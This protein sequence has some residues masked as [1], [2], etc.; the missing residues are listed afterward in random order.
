MS[1]ASVHWEEG[2]F[3]RPHH[4]QASQRHGAAASSLGDKWDRHHNW[5]LRGLDLNPDALSNNRFEVRSLRA[6]MRDGTLVSVP[7]DGV[8]TPLDLKA[9]LE[10]GRKA[11]VYLAVPVFHPSRNNV[12]Q[13]GQDGHVRYRVESRTLEDENTGVNPQSV[14]FRRLNLELLAEGQ[15]LTGYEVLPIARMERSA[16]AEATPQLDRSYIPPL[17]ACDGWAPLMQDVLRVIYDRLGRKLE[18]LAGQ[19]VSRKIPL[20]STGRAETLLFAQLRE[21]NPAFS[22]L[23][24]LCFTEGVHPFAAY[25]ELARLVGQLGVFDLATRRP[26]DLPRYD[27]DDLARCFYAAKKAVDALLDVF[28]EPEYKERAFLGAGYRMQVELDSAWVEGGW[29]VYIGVKSGLEREAC[30]EALTDQGIL[31]MK[32]GSARRVD[33]I[34]KARDQGLRFDPRPSPPRD[35]PR[36]T[37]LIYFQIDPESEPDE[38]QYVKQTRSLAVRLNEGFILGNIQDQRDLNVRM[39]D[40][41]PTTMQF[42]VYVVPSGASRPGVGGGA[43]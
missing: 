24:Q 37:G 25:L 34:F 19:A 35:L 29:D 32:V 8:L 31:D 7:E 18:M 10:G 23:S 15:D 36:E 30:V 28:V 4:F 39:P 12:P 43:S 40:G 16:R 41:Q 17:V 22:V 42:T 20:D 1:H 6:R 5:G 38:W 14:R 33:S 2:M 27:H 13:A 11:M 21:M 9:A 3:L 26:P